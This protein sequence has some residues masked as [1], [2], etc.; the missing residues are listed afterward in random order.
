MGGGI[1]KQYRMCGSEPVLVKSCRAFS[2]DPRVNSIVVA[3]PEGDELKA[4]LDEAY[5]LEL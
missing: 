2:E 5:R 1:P 4:I 3:V